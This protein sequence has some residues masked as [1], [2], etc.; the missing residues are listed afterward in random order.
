[1]TALQHK[2]YSGHHRAIEEGRART[3]NVDNRLEQLEENG[4]D[5]TRQC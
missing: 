3:R 4:D 2:Y 1:M 5:S